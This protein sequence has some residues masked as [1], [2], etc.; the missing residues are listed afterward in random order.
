MQWNQ[1]SLDLATARRLRLRRQAANSLAAT[2]SGMCTEAPLQGSTNQWLG[3]MR[4]R[5]PDCSRSCRGRC[6]HSVRRHRRHC[7]SRLASQ[8]TQW[9]AGARVRARAAVRVALVEAVRKRATAMVKV[10]V[11]VMEVNAEAEERDMVAATEMVV[12]REMVV[13]K[14]EVVAREMVAR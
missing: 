5:C 14:K 13:A 1:A 4:V 8:R 6:T 10:G 2:E 11:P 12:A 9:L 3:V 7:T